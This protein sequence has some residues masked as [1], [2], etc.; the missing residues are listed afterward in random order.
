MVF[1]KLI[2][3]QSLLATLLF[4]GSSVY[5]DEVNKMSI[6]DGQDKQ[7]KVESFNFERLDS[8]DAT[9]IK[10]ETNK[11]TKVS[12]SIFDKNNRPVTTVEG[13][14][15]PPLTEIK[16]RSKNVMVTSV[17]CFEIEQE[18]NQQEDKLMEMYYKM[19]TFLLDKI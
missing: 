17:R 8:E 4:L 12:C 10:I 11:T 9:T 3:K 18:I 16:A 14:I 7:I 5:A 1:N 2:Q 13:E 15:K 19:P 6:I